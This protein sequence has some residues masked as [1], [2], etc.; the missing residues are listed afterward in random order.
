MPMRLNG[1]KNAESRAKAIASTCGLTYNQVHQICR[2][3]SSDEKATRRQA[4]GGSNRQ[5]AKPRAKA[6]VKSLPPTLAVRDELY[7][8]IKATVAKGVP[9][10]FETTSSAR[11]TLRCLNTVSPPTRS[12]ANLGGS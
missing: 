9:R 6:A 11:F 5:R 8:R 10:P 1:S 4:F 2:S 3:L 7:Q 12:S